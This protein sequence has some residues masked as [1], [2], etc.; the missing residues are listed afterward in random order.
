MV[1]LG[2]FEPKGGAFLVLLADGTV[3]HVRVDGKPQ[4]HRRL[5]RGI[6]RAASVPETQYQVVALEDG[7]IVLMDGTGRIRAIQRLADTEIRWLSPF[8]D[9][10][11]IGVT[12]T[13]KQRTFRLVCRPKPGRTSRHF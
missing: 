11:V 5:H 6:T 13:T 10:G 1:S 12:V 4:S 3:L 8:H 2:R 9:N 7:S